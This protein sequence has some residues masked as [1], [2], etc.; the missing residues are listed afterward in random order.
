M[1]Y[2]VDAW[3]F[4]PDFIHDFLRTVP[5]CTAPYL[6]LSLSLSKGNLLV[7]RVI[8]RVQSRK[9]FEL[10]VIRAFWAPSYH[11]RALSQVLSLHEGGG[12]GPA[13]IW[14]NL[15]FTIWTNR[16]K[17]YLSIIL[18]TYMSRI[19]FRILCRYAFHTGGRWH[20]GSLG[21]WVR[22]T[23]ATW[24]AVGHLLWRGLHRHALCHRRRRRPRNPRRHHIIASWNH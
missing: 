8:S 19:T 20:R 18:N 13:T 9:S 5:S 23:R 6:T 15:F 3:P 2:C 1:L 12:P 21:H 24:G 7:S 10:R 11:L 22:L 4:R 16:S 17:C 14:T